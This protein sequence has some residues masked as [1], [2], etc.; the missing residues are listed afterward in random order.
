MLSG[1]LIFASLGKRG[2]VKIIHEHFHQRGAVQ[3]GQA[4]N[5]AYDANVPE[6][7]DGFA[8]LAILVANQNHAVDWKLRRMQRRQR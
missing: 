7:L 5:F 8:I 2:A 1:E 4:R 3:I 6:A